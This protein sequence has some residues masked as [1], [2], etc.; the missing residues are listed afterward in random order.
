[1]LCLNPKERIS[2]E[3]IVNHPFITQESP[4]SDVKLIDC[5]VVD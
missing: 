5:V 4:K 1:M 3:A 2:V